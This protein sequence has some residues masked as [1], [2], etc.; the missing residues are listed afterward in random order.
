MR[1]INLHLHYIYITLKTLDRVVVKVP[2]STHITPILKSLHW[3]KVN[4]RIEQTSVSYLQSSH[5]QSTTQLSS[6]SDF[7]NPLAVPAPTLSCPPHHLLTENH[8]SLI[9]ICI[10]SY[11]ES[12]SRFISST[13]FISIHLIHQPFFCYHHHSQHP[14]FLHSSNPGPK[15]T[16]S[17]NLTHLNKLLVAPFTDHSRLDYIIFIFS[18][19]F[20]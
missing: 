8:R 5:N 12:T 3:L 1:Y 11:L 15:P 18:S 10:T 16:F 7:F 20:V 6:Q 14:L 9:Q 17:T 13:N 2:K 19:F 4:E